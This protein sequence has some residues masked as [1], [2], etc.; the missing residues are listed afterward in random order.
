MLLT[1]LHETI[2]K[3][4]KTT[5]ELRKLLDVA[6]CEGLEVVSATEVL[7]TRSPAYIKGLTTAG[8]LP[9]KVTQPE[10]T[11]NIELS[12]AV[13]TMRSMQGLSGL[14]LAKLIINTVISGQ[15]RNIKSILSKLASLEGMPLV[16]KLFQLSNAPELKTLK[17]LNIVSGAGVELYSC[18]G[19]TSLAEITTKCTVSVTGCRNMSFK[20]MPASVTK[21]NLEYFSF[22]SGLPWLVMIPASCELM[23]ADVTIKEVDGV[24]SRW[25]N[26]TA[27]G[28]GVPGEIIDRILELQKKGGTRAD[29]L[30]IQQDLIEADCDALAKL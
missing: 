14:K 20:N 8:T 21:L 11:D 25:W 1:S 30:R 6:D 10:G 26:S 3:K 27:S 23:L 4:A 22:K 15:H 9:F 19:L 16:H 2:T 7:I 5:D 24:K 12:V 28:D 17:G 29:M 13:P 18:D